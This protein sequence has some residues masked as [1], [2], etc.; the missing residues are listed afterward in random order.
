MR[1]NV[2]AGAAG[3][4]IIVAIA[5]TARPAVQSGSDVQ[6]LTKVEQGW[7]D[8]LI[9]ADGRALKQLYADEYTSTDSDGVVTNKAQDIASVTSGVVK[10]TSASLD[11][12]KIRRYGDVA[13]VTGR[14]TVKITVAGKDDSGPSR[15]TDVFVLRDGRWQCVATQWARVT[16]K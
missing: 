16:K 14:S 10:L 5:A 3:A 7:T 15:F 1:L 2:A 9:H 13:V 6:A 4:L 11:D 8:A 12:M